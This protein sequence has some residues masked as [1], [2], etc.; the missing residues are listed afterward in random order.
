MRLSAEGSFDNTAFDLSQVELKTSAVDVKA[1]GQLDVSENLF[2]VRVE[3]AVEAPEQDILNKVLGSKTATISGR[4]IQEIAGTLLFSDIEINSSNLV[5]TGG[6]QLSEGTIQ[7]STQLSLSDLSP[8]RDGLEGGLKADVQLSGDVS[9]PTIEVDAE[10]LDISV[11]DNPLENFTVKASGVAT[12]VNPSADLE[13]SGRY[14]GQ[15]VSVKATVTSGQNGGPVVDSLNLSVPGA[16]ANGQL[17][18][19]D[20]GIFTGELDVEV[21]SLAELG[22]L[23]LQENLAGSLSG[24]VVFSEKD[25]AQSITAN[26]SAPEISTGPV[27]AN[28]LAVNVVVDDVSDVQAFS[29]TATV[30]SVTASGTTVEN[31]EARVSGSPEQLPFSV[32][33]RLFDSP[34]AFEGELSSQHGTTTIELSK[35]DATVRSIPLALIE[36]VSLTFSESGTNVETATPQSRAQARLLSAAPPA[37]RS[38]LTSTLIH[39]R[40]SC[41]KMSPRPVL[42]RA[43]HF[44]ALRKSPASRP[45]QA[46]PTN[47]RSP[48]FR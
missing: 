43:V 29:A 39:F 8:L 41:S 6:G 2:N 48:I 23:L 16:R 46:S 20:A 34:M 14:E 22:P 24:S 4:L 3:A 17:V 38:I 28:T 47:W 36:P 31:I 9:R 11:L 18:A 33:G 10:G 35:A 45:I 19:N 25:A 21:T 13:V 15:P 27:E 1:S 37:M 12:T 7:A 5:A 40:W 30:Q 32:S 44:P 42:A 26:F